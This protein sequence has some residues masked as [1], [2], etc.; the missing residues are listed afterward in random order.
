M[1]GEEFIVCRRCSEGPLPSLSFPLQIRAPAAV[2]AQHRARRGGDAVPPVRAPRAGAAAQAAGA[3]LHQEA[4][5]L[6]LAGG[7]RGPG[8]V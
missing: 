5:H 6:A 2:A 1:G 4:R 7:A 3:R 8:G